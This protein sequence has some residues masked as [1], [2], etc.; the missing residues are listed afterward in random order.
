MTAI[1]RPRALPRASQRSFAVFAALALALTSVAF[2]ATSGGAA[3]SDPEVVFDNTPSFADQGN[4][5]SQ[6][7]QYGIEQYGDIINLGGVARTAD[8]ASIWLNSWACE[9]GSPGNSATPS[10][11]ETTPGAAYTTDMTLRIYAPDTQQIDLPTSGPT[12]ATV[13]LVGEELAAVTET[14]T[15]PYRPASDTDECT[16]G[17]YLHPD[18][19]TCEPATPFLATFDLASLELELPEQIIVALDRPNTGTNATGNSRPVNVLLPG[20]LN[21]AGSPEDY[22][23]NEGW[24]PTVGSDPAEDVNYVMATSQ[25]GSALGEGVFGPALWG[26]TYRPAFVI[27][28]TAV[29]EEPTPQPGEPGETASETIVLGESQVT[30]SAELGDHPSGE[31]VL[32][33]SYS[34]NPAEFGTLPGDAQF[35]F[36]AYS[37]ELN[38]AVGSTATVTIETPTP[39]NTLFK[40]IDNEWSEYPATFAGTSIT[41]DLVDGGPGDADGVA[42]GIIVDPVA[43]AVMATF[44]G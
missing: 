15:V 44:T 1:A 19:D 29:V 14:I 5:P 7:W 23:V 40:S 12:Q 42:N 17:D 30:V 18:T 38:V 28:A 26:P 33:S 35:A 27:T 10:T 36:G 22:P 20:I 37:F 32:S 16:L 39:A 2:T 34:D 8:T 41:F 25:Y 9:E 31:L 6:S 11:C 13:P 3:Q 21:S 24:G 4:Y 43:P